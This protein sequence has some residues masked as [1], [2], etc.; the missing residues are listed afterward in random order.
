MIYI[1]IITSIIDYE[2]HDYDDYDI[3]ATLILVTTDKLMIDY[4]LPNEDTLHGQASYFITRFEAQIIMNHNVIV[5][6]G[7]TQHARQ[8]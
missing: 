8:A 1:I 3:I 6:N 4:P 2:V 5:D 7:F